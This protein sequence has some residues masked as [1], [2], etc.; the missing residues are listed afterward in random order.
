MLVPVFDYI[1]TVS[2]LCNRKG[3]EGQ[4]KSNQCKSKAIRKIPHVATYVVAEY[5]EVTRR[6][7]NHR[8]VLLLCQISPS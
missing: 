8:N 1:I 3:R 7:V 5:T 2:M 6:Y 4:Q